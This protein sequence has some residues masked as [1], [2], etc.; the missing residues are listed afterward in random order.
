MKVLFVGIGSI[1]TRHL[2]N[3][4]AACAQRGIDLEV[5]AL[6]SSLRPLAEETAQ[7]IAKQITELDDTVYD[8][9]FITNPTNLHYNAVK[10]LKGKAK[11]FFIEKPIF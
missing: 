5:T 1:G 8:L 11:F 6:R 7:L 3:L 4:T 10:D 2:K 9:A